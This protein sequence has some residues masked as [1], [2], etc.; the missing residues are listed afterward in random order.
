[1]ATSKVNGRKVIEKP[2]SGQKQSA[3]KCNSASTLQRIH[4]QLVAL[5]KALAGIRA[6]FELVIPVLVSAAPGLSCTPS[7]HS[8]VD[9]SVLSFAQQC[10]LEVIDAIPRRGPEIARRAGYTYVSVRHH[11]SLLRKLGLIEHSTRGYFRV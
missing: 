6:E 11:L 8:S 9:E 4:V 7:K 2:T 10:V 1:M 3:P 5:E